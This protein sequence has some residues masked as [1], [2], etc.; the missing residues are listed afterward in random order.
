M[1]P[2]DAALRD[3]LGEL[4]RAGYAFVT[5]T[6]AT[7]SRVLARD[8]RPA[9]DLRDILGWSRPFDRDTAPAWLLEALR[10]ARLLAVDGERFRSR[11]R[12]SRLH[13]RL[14]IH[15]AFP[16]TEA[17]AVFFGPD[18]YRFADFV[19]RELQG[20]EAGR[21]LDVGGGAGVG[22][23]VAQG[24][25]PSAALYLTDINPLALRFARI[26]AAHA[27]ARLQ[28]IQASGLD[29][30]AGAMDVIIANPPYMAASGQTYRHGGGEQGERLSLEWAR[31]ALER[32]APGGRLLLYTGTAIQNGA[33]A[34]REGLAV[35]AEAHGARFEYREVDPDVFGE[36]LDR[37]AY[38]NVERIAAVTCVMVAP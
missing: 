31:A 1:N 7:H 2:A 37:P 19:R 4:D 25:S 5:P 14:F 12:V 29:A 9:R 35:L 18:S 32:L 36:E 6:P 24:A 34:V 16:T 28:A 38:A 20:R 17:D 23:V 27:G 15:S 3:L 13:D 30:V 10:A 11:I 33:D 21:I 22:A 26:N 8:P